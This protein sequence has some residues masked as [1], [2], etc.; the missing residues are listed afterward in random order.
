MFIVGVAI[1]FAVANRIKKGD[2]NKSITLH[3]LKR[4]FLLLVFRLGAILHKR[5]ENCVAVSKC[6]GTTFS[7]IPGRFPY[8]KQKLFL[9]DNF[10]TYH[11]LLIDLAYRFSRWKILI[12]PG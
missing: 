10:Y 4:A 2:S 9:P 8:E 11:S 1:P 12:T 6:P 5:R 7:H 3:A